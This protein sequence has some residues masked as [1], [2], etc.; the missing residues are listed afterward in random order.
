[1]EKHNDNMT[2]FTFNKTDTV[3]VN[4]SAY[5]ELLE[6]NTRYRLLV[7]MLEQS[8]TLDGCGD[9]TIDYDGRKIINAAF[10]F[11]EPE[12]YAWRIRQLKS[13][14]EAADA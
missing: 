14:K 2:I 12:A 4:S 9:P 11:I 1:M 6:Q 5:H 7:K 8:I 10:K 13:E 3:T